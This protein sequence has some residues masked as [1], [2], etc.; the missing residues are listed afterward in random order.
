MLLIP[1]CVLSFPTTVS[2]N[3]EFYKRVTKMKEWLSA[4][5]WSVGTLPMRKNY[6]TKQASGTQII[7]TL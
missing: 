4:A 6:K 1:G 7:L 2:R 5:W 3:H